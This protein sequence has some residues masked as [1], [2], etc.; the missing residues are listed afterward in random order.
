MSW[1]TIGCSHKSVYAWKKNVTP[2]VDI[3]IKIA[4]FFEISLD[5]LILK[6]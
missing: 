1:L 3:L 2:S 5:E 6:K 4:E